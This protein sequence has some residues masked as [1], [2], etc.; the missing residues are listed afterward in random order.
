MK[1]A[2]KL[3]FDRLPTTFDGLIQLHA[4]RPI[5]NG[6]G[7][8]NTVEIVDAL[9]GHALNQDQEDYLLLLSALIERYEADTLVSSCCATSSMKTDLAGTIWPGLSASIA[10]SLIGFSRENAASRLN[11]SKRF[12]RGHA[13][14]CFHPLA[15]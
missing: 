13:S 5:H 15:V 9:A 14:R 11:T 8:K 4:P 3:S 6:V 2:R 7:H 10:R 1:P 12:A